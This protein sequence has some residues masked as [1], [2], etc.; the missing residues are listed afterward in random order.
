MHPSPGSC[1]KFPAWSWVKQKLWQLLQLHPRGLKWHMR[2]QPGTSPAWPCVKGLSTCRKEAARLGRASATLCTFLL[3][4]PLAC[5]Q[6]RL[7]QC[8]A[9]FPHATS[10]NM[11]TPGAAGVNPAWPSCMQGPG[12]GQETCQSWTGAAPPNLAVTTWH[13]LKQ[14]KGIQRGT[15]FVV[16]APWP[17]LAGPG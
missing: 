13:S 2:I 12:I 14:H 3:L 5:S 16:P 17:G 7:G 4:A 6:I 10:G 1:P 9:R 11:G 15:V 8:Y